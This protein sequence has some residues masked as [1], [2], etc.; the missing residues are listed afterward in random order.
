[1]IKDGGKVIMLAGLKASKQR[2]KTKVA[3][4]T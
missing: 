1:M 3:V 4:V 2:V